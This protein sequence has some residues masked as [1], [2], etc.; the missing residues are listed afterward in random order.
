MGILDNEIR[1]GFHKRNGLLNA[2]YKEEWGEAYAIIVPD[3]GREGALENLA[4]ELYDKMGVGLEISDVNKIGSLGPRYYN[5]SIE[6]K[7]SFVLSS[8]MV[9]SVA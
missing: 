1:I 4:F 8:I 2:K 7:F 3:E 9:S 5:L 6:E